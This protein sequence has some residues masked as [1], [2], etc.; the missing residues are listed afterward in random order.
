MFDDIY[1]MIEARLDDGEFIVTDD[2]YIEGR[3]FLESRGHVIIIQYL[4]T[5][6]LDYH[7]VNNSDLF[8]FMCDLNLHKSN[9]LAVVGKYV[10]VQ[11]RYDP[12]LVLLKN[13]LDVYIVAKPLCVNA[14]VWIELDT[15]ESV[16]HEYE[17]LEIGYNVN[18][19]FTQK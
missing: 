3:S 10:I 11:K 1:S 19:D 6:D 18:Y 17:F 2:N 16:K 15:W 7:M 13:K 4:E 5:A 9:E 14:I 8:A 12:R